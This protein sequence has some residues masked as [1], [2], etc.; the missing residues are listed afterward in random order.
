MLTIARLN[1]YFYH[2]LMLSACQ[3]YF[4]LSECTLAF[5]NILMITR[6]VFLLMP[7]YSYGKCQLF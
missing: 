5:S 4:R 3:C 7:V 2:H 6:F 1:C